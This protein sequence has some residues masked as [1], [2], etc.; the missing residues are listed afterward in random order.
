MKH[1]ER[2]LDGQN[3]FW[4]YLAM[5]LILFLGVSTIGSFPLIITMIVHTIK[6]GI[7]DIVSGNITDLS[8][9]GITGN[10]G[11]FLLL[12]TF[13]PMIFAFKWLVRPFHKRTITETING[14]NHLRK[15]RIGMGMLVWGALMSL[16]LIYG[17]IGSPENYQFQFHLGRFLLLLLITLSILPFQT[18]FEELFFR[19]YLSQGVAAA[20][21]SRWA[22]LIIISLAFGLMHA[23]NPEVKEFGFWI[24]IPSYI[25]MGVILGA[26]SIL[27]DG[28][29]LAI[30]IHFIN[31]AFI[32]LFTTHSSSVFQTDALFRVK[33][34]DPV[35]ELIW[36][37]VFAV[38]VILLL[39]KI[40]HWDFAI[41]KQKITV[42]P[43]PLPDPYTSPDDNSQGK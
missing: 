35:G 13:L 26:V 22:T 43:P 21:R 34:I 30:G 15:G 11:F 40:Y 29:E 39:G 20:T 36:M 41:F 24:S 19:G 4:K 42:T 25:L 32:A 5:T 17:L 10:T 33:E 9:Y 7:P 27:D 37:G 1:L 31:N 18:T 8:S 6:N 28:I 3:S 16:T 38:V 2:A 23:L 12:L 14:R